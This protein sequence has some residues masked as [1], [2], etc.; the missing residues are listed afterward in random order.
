VEPEVVSAHRSFAKD[1]MA[2][3]NQTVQRISFLRELCAGKEVL[4]LGCSNWPYTQE[5]DGK[6]L[7]LHRDIDEVANRCCGL[8]S[9]TAG[10]EELKKLGFSDLVVGDIEHLEELAEHGCFDVV[11][12]GE[13]IEHLNNPGLFLQSVSPLLRPGGVLVITTV[14][15]YCAF[16]FAQ[17]ALRGRGGSQEPVHPDHVA[18]YSQS[19][20]RLLVERAG[21]RVDELVF[22][23]LGNEHRRFT[24]RAV[25]VVNDLVVR[26]A[27]HL[28]DGLIVVC[29]PTSSEPDSFGG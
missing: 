9:D 14:N 29:S 18:Y 7:L 5:S 1:W 25:R 12:A 8:D 16:R 27:K 13:V 19:T 17:Y 21:W 22:Y 2:R 20:L 10:L 4:H 11:L 24:T 3:M 6:G 26:I 23:D 28:S 15:A